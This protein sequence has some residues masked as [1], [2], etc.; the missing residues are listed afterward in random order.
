MSS[1]PKI[2]DGNVVNITFTP[3]RED[4]AGDLTIESCD[5]GAKEQLAKLSPRVGHEEMRAVYVDG[6]FSRTFKTKK[7]RND[8]EGWFPV[9][10]SVGEEF[11]KPYAE[12][13]K[14]R[15]GSDLPATLNLRKYLKWYGLCF[16]MVTEN[17]EIRHGDLFYTGYNQ[18]RDWNNKKADVNA[19]EYAFENQREAVGKIDP[20]PQ[21]IESGWGN[22][23]LN[24]AYGKKQYPH[25]A[26]E[27][28]NLWL[29]IADWWLE[30][31]ANAAQR[32]LV[33]ADEELNTNN[34]RNHRDRYG[35][36]RGLRSSGGLRS[37]WKDGFFSWDEFKELK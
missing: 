1:I 4:G 24:P 13:L 12:E 17:W 33:E 2:E 30:N 10:G 6:P 23:K 25:P 32:E 27:S 9:F 21:F 35:S 8:Y 5:V 14:R 26:L 3:W 36:F 37:D 15:T 28:E 20:V 7:D 18:G 31:V 22:Y 11:L 29:G 16:V 19:A 34:M